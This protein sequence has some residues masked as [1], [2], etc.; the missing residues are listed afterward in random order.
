MLSIEE[1]A[2]I[3]DYGIAGPGPTI[4]I[5]FFPNTKPDSG[6]LSFWSA[7]GLAGDPDNA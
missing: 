7:S 6:N 5:D 4:D 1:L 2:S 3:V